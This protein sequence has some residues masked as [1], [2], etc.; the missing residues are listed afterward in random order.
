MLIGRVMTDGR[1]NAR[2]KCDLTDNLTLKVNAQVDGSKS[3]G[4][5]VHPFLR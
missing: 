2:V 4:S 3:L 1:L 5:V